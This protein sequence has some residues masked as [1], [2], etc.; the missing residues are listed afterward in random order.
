MTELYRVNDAI[1]LEGQRLVSD[2]LYIDVPTELPEIEFTDNSSQRV[3]KKSSISR[4]VQG[5]DIYKDFRQV[6]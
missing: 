1:T 2:T 3:M 6:K 4:N 5:L